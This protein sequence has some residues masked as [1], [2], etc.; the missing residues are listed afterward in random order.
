[1]R[2]CDSV[3][4]NRVSHVA[5]VLQAGFFTGGIT[6]ALNIDIV[7][8]PIHTVIPV[9][10]PVIVA[11]CIYQALLFL[12]L[13]R[14]KTRFGDYRLDVLLGAF[15][16]MGLLFVLA[17]N[18]LFY[19]VCVTTTGFI[20]LAVWF[21]LTAM[22]F[23]SLIVG[24]R[25]RTSSS[26][27]ASGPV[28]LMF[29]SLI[30]LIFQAGRAMTISPAFG[31]TLLPRRVSSSD[32]LDHERRF[33]VIGIDALQYELVTGLAN[34]GY[35]PYFRAQLEISSAG[36]LRTHVPTSSPI[37]WT[38]IATGMLPVSHGIRDFVT[39]RHNSSHASFDLLPRYLMLG[40]ILKRFGIHPFPISSRDRREFTFWEILSRNWGTVGIVNW[41]AT[42]PVD[43]VNGFFIGNMLYGQKNG[44]VDSVLADRQNIMYPADGSLDDAIRE[45]FGLARTEL[46]AAAA[47]VL[48]SFSG[49]G[50]LSEAERYRQILINDVALQPDLIA[51][52]IGRILNKRFKPR[53][54][55]V[56][57]NGLDI[58]KH[59]CYRGQDGEQKIS[60]AVE[61]EAL[62]IPVTIVRYYQ[63]LD[64][65]IGMLAG[66][67]D[68]QRT[69]IIL[70][71]HGME[72]IPV[73]R[74]FHYKYVRNIP[75]LQGYHDKAPAGCYLINGEGIRSGVRT[76]QATVYDIAPT[77]LHL[78]GLPVSSRMAGQPYGP[79]FSEVWL[80][81]HPVRNIDDYGIRESR[82]KEF[83]QS[84]SQQP[85]MLHLLRSLGYLD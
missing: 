58:T 47:T 66:E 72:P 17:G 74:R 22:F 79:L 8:R 32:V 78:A 71:D 73:L 82:A 30:L 35:L 76:G 18:M 39:Y 28:L 60:I 85:E 44:D 84:Q 49:K 10:I 65:L 26:R 27:L 80:K 57:L 3:F 61:G 68:P 23:L 9:T 53:L 51:A 69:V 36:K 67:H 19:R 48:E 56:Y 6:L 11:V 52:H 14:K 2:G 45:A 38:T 43:P 42:I 15:V 24:A 63:F 55:A 4:N 37:I 25:V 16:P 20:E 40:T 21:V 77:I 41:W 50:A 75:H 81:A 83:P 46:P 34:A 33:F 5:I 64:Y 7:Q 12:V 70:S 62:T 29:L 54:F 59:L 31:G 13:G 1:M